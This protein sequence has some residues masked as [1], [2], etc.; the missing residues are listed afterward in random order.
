MN[1]QLILTLIAVVIGGSLVMGGRKLMK[2]NNEGARRLKMVMLGIIVL[3]AG[4]FA[5]EA[6]GLG[7]AVIALAALGIAVWVTKGFKQK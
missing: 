3:I 7:G 1:E 5:V 4:A 6:F 2:S